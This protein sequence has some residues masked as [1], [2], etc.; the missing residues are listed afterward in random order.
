MENAKIFLV[1]ICMGLSIN[2]LAPES[3][4]AQNAT[5]NYWNCKNRVGGEWNFGRVPSACDV[6]PLTDEDLL[7]ENYNSVVFKDGESR[8][9]ERMRYMNDLQPFLRDVV[10]EYLDRRKPNASQTERSAFV[11]AIYTLAHSESFWS[12]YREAT[13]Q[14]LKVTRGDFGHGHGLFQVDDRWHYNAVKNGEAWKLL[15]NIEYGLDIY[16]NEWQRAASASCVSSPTDWRSRTRAAWAAFNGGPRKLCRWTNP[17]DRWAHNDKN[18]YEKFRSQLWDR[19]IEDYDQESKVNLSCLRENRSLPCNE[20]EPG[21]VDLSDKQIITEQG[22]HCILQDDNLSCIRQ[23]KNF[24]CLERYIGKSTNKAYRA[25]EL[26]LSGKTKTLYSESTLCPD[27]I[28]G[29]FAVGSSVQLEK[30]INFRKSAGGELIRTLASGAVLTVLDYEVQEYDMGKRWYKVYFRGDNGFIYAGTESTYLDWAQKVD[31]DPQFKWI[32]KIGDEVTISSEAGINLRSEIRGSLV[33]HVAFGSKVE[34]LNRSI[35]SDE[36]R[37]YYQVS[38]KGQLGWI[39]GGR[40]T[41]DSTYRNWVQF[42]ET[43][44]LYT[45]RAD[46]WYRFLLECPELE[47]GVI[48]D[49]VRSPLLTPGG[50]SME[51]V[52]EQ[53]DWVRVRKVSSGSIGWIRKSDLIDFQG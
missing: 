40:S 7:A 45:L 33:G 10:L 34:I 26:E 2:L 4:F 49:Y 47:C 6:S 31:E 36:R 50:D 23:S 19:Y 37:V 17:N 5:P 22:H 43:T 24:T 32:A 9:S 21:P 39:Y 3:S 28:D 8:S 27:T 35:E 52:D 38:H 42:S 30:N 48:D 44:P 46:M 53:G 1:T 13:D 12:H 20:V 41:P 18:F 11:Y 51:I 14:K 15:F 25:S 16:F 29:L